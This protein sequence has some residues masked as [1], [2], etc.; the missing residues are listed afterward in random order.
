MDKNYRG[1]RSC[2]EKLQNSLCFHRYFWFHNIKKKK[3]KVMQF[4][5]LQLSNL[6]MQMVNVVS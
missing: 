2:L 6:F 4:R 3:C 5:K 1:G